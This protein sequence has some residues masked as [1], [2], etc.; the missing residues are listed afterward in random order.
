YHERLY[1]AGNRGEA[2]QEPPVFE[3]L[4]IGGGTPTCLAG[5]DL[6]WLVGMLFERFAF[7]DGA[8][9]TCEANP[10]SS[11]DE[12]YA[13][14]RAAGVNR[15]SIGIQSLDD[16]LLQLIGRVHTAEEAQGAIEAARRAGFDNLNVDL[17]FALP[18]QRLQVWSDTLEQI[19][20]HSPEHLSCY[21]LI[22]ED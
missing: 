2:D 13:A 17:M 9:V 11:N 5:K 18:G 21:S 6:A 16:A 3:T 14:L 12:K 1:G 22:V 19:L 4:F 15:L 10:G 7:A 8:E 20:S